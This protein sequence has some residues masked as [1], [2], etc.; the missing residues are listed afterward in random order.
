MNALANLFQPVSQW[1]NALQKR[2]RNIVIGGSISFFVMMF[3]LIIWEPITSNYEQQQ[4][5]NQSQRQLYSWMKQAANEIQA[6]NASGGS[7]ASRFRNQSISSLADRSA[8]TTGIKPYINKIDQSKDGVKVNLKQA[9]F[10]MLVNWLTDLENK[11]G[12]TTTRIKI[13]KSITPG[14]VN[15][16]ITLERAQ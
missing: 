13:E 8:S 9:S 3:Y 5:S 10:D 11:Y 1:F 14:A 12:I 6:I 7:F 2:E 15:A 16:D 4:L